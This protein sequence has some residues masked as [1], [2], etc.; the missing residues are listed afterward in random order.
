MTS[1]RSLQR[2]IHS[3]MAAQLDRVNADNA[4]RRVEELEQALADRDRQIARLQ[5]KLQ[6][7]A[8]KISRLEAQLTP[9]DDAGD[10]SGLR[11]TMTIF[12]RPATTIQHVALHYGV[13]VSTVFRRLQPGNKQR[14]AGG[15]LPGTNR[16]YVFLDQPIGS[17]R[18]R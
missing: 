3:S 18:T 14:I 15:Q 1:S 2:K 9:A 6:S 12:G 8:D 5:N 17:F 11:P 7:A 16:W 4:Q 10:D 13:H